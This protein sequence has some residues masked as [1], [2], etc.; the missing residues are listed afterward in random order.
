MIAFKFVYELMGIEQPDRL[1]KT[2]A[3]HSTR[4]IVVISMPIN[5]AS[6][7]RTDRRKKL[8]LPSH[9]NSVDLD[10]SNWKYHMRFLFQTVAIASLSIN[11]KLCSIPEDW[12]RCV[13]SNMS[14]GTQMSMSV[15][16]ENSMNY[17]LRWMDVSTVILS[18]QKQENATVA[19]SRP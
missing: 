14:N 15:L 19:S 18:M 7:Y 9:A 12:R 1:I 10:K 11:L 3:F 16:C 17:A 6:D 13:H 4:C 8:L 2:G 5:D